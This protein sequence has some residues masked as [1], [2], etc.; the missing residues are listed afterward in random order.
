MAASKV[1]WDGGD[2]QVS[3][4][5]SGGTAALAAGGLV[6]T[7]TY[8][9]RTITTARRQFAWLELLCTFAVAPAAND[10]IEV[11]FVPAADLGTVNY[12]DTVD[13]INP[14][15]RVATIPVRAVTTAQRIPHPIVILGP[16][17]FKCPLRNSTGQTISAGWSLLITTFDNENQ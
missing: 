17:A 8:E 16:M 14:A 12:G 6:T 3:I 4:Y 11:Y 2:A 5:A 9:N 10:A 7:G 15:L 1:L 13:P